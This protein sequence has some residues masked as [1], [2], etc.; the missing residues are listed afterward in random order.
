MTDPSDHERFAQW[1][2]SYVL[3]ALSPSER[4][5]YEAHVETCERCRAAVAELAPMPGLLSRLTAEQAESIGREADDAPVPARAPASSRVPAASTTDGP[6]ADLLSLVVARDRRRRRR[7]VGLVLA[8]A[9]AVALLVTVP[10]AVTQMGAPPAS[11]P[12]ALERT[13]PTTALS[14]DVRL[15]SVGWGTRIDM[16]CA[17]GPNA[18]APPKDGWVYGLYVVDRDGEESQV[19]TWK[20]TSRSDVKLTAA[21]ALARD[22]I[23]RVE[24]RALP[25]G[26]ELLGADPS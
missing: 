9:A 15:T 14:A 18:A 7:R 10:L 17:Y 21:T 22:E 16:D 4:R 6:P 2:A 8:A 5:E 1:D 24:V 25:S 13:L 26:E 11:A 20:V 23:A 3:G 12:I 19:S